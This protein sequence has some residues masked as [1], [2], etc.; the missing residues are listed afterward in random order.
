MAN[1][2]RQFQFG[3]SAAAWQKRVIPTVCHSHFEWRLIEG[4][5]S[6]LRKPR[7]GR[8]ILITVS[9]FHMRARHKRNSVRFVHMPYSARTIP[10][11]RRRDP[12]RTRNP[13][14][15][16]CRQTFPT[17]YRKPSRWRC[18]WVADV[19]RLDDGRHSPLVGRLDD[20]SLMS[21]VEWLKCDFGCVISS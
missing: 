19:C 7:R 11:G 14:K 15:Y 2:V 10:M 8:T 21:S 4:T 18:G 20:M 16:A 17:F 3:T 9:W 6:G 1:K 12:A 5:V 13:Y